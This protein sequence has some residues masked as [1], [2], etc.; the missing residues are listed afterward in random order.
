[1]LTTALLP[2]E[3]RPGTEFS[4]SY[5]MTDRRNAIWQV[6]VIVDGLACCRTRS[7]DRWRYECFGPG[8][9]RANETNIEWRT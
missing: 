1:M 9:F 8:F 2:D 3:C 4:I 6:R 5:G 7:G